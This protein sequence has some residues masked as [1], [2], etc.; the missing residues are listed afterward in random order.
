MDWNNT[1]GFGINGNP[2]LVAIYTGS[3]NVQD[4]RIAYSNDEGI[5][6]T[7]YIGNPV[8]SMH[9]NQFRDP[10][11]LWHEAIQKW[12]MVV[13]VGWYQGIRFYNSADL[14]NWTF[15]AWL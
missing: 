12:I 10:K 13:S 7:N 3:S 6:W 5:T 2:P 1:S 8:L 14:K 4:Q 11:V 9:N 15:N